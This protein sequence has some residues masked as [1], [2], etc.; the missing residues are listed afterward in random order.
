MEEVK[1]IK[2][3]KIDKETKKKIEEGIKQIKRGEYVSFEELEKD[4]EKKKK[5]KNND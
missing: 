5:E 3:V 2:T 1:K 4:F